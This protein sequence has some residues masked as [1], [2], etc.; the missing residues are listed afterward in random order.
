M[1]K[2][3]GL[4]LIALLIITTGSAYAQTTFVTGKAVNKESTLPIEG[5]NITLLQGNDITYRTASDSLGN[6]KIPQGLYLQMTVL[7][8]TS[9]NYQDLKINKKFTV[10]QL[11]NN[12]F[13]LGLFALKPGK[14]EL[15]EVKVNSKRRYSDTTNIDL[16]KDKFERSIMM[17]DLFSGN[18]GFTKDKNGRIYYKGTLVSNILVDGGDFFGKNNF[19]IYHLLPA[20]TMENIQVVETNIDSTTNTTKLRPVVKV[21][22]TLKPKYNKGKFGNANAGGGTASRYL[23]NTDLYGYRNKQ[24]MSLDLNLNNIN[25]GDNLITPPS[26]S[27]SATGNSLNA[28]GGKFTYHNILAKKVE[29]NFDIKG[30]LDN[31]LYTSLSERNDL[32]I[33][34]YSKTTNSSNTKTFGIDNANFNINYRADPLN[35]FNISQTVGSVN[36]RVRDSLNYIIKADSTNTV[37]K[38][39]R[40]S[41]SLTNNSSSKVLYLHRFGSKKGRL[42]NVSAIYNNNAYHI[43]ESDNIYNLS[44]NAATTYFVDGKRLVTNRQ[45]LINTSYTEPLT[46]NSFVTIFANY[47]KDDIVESD[48]V[49]S[50][51]AVNYLTPAGIY[52][53]YLETGLKF[54]RT[55]SK[56]AVDGNVTGIFNSKNIRAVNSGAAN[57]F[58]VNFDLKTDYK[59]DPRKNLLLTYSL[60]TTYPD[61]HQLSSLNSN[62][63]LVSQ[64]SGNPNLKPQDDYSMKAAYDLKTSDTESLLISGQLD[65]FTSKFGYAIATTGTF[66]SSITTNVGNAKSGTFSFSFNKNFASQRYINS[67]SSVSYQENPSFVSNKRVLNSGVLLNQLVSTTLPI[68]KSV[69]TLTPL[70]AASYSKFNFGTGSNNVITFT[71]SDRVSIT[72]LKSEISLFPLFTYSHNINDNHSFSMNGEIKRSFFKNLVSAWVQAYD[73]FNSFKFY[74]NY[75]GPT[76]TQTISYSN[77]QRY[78]FLGVSYKFNNFK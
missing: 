35:S 18:Y 67:T 74:N 54:Q 38:V 50:D 9:I 43:N 37:S 3:P 59:V 64:V 36:T 49:K 20:L 34:Q 17:D 69:V 75:V 62:F 78:V 16:S 7:K 28:R 1:I 19:D 63:D 26:V 25:A 2:I 68:I 5:A 15:Q 10:E 55:F 58:K 22:L 72:A 44:N 73:I 53:Q 71:Y 77:I 29:V 57:S 56:V 66:L 27:F 52:N 24:Q 60:V 39:G 32:D 61:I 14:I 40:V 8:I 11:K 51:T 48:N 33:R 12:N 65:Y 76:Y 4:L 70:L 21:N 13:H 30:R 6:F 42:L 41:N 23:A 46:E 47:K 31:K 45:L